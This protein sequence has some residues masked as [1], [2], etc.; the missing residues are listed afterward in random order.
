MYGKVMIVNEFGTP[1]FGDG[2]V[3]IKSS[4]TSL[5]VTVGTAGLSGAL[6]VRDFTAGVFHMGT[7]WTS[8]S[9][10]FKVSSTSTGTF[11]ALYDHGGTLV[12]IPTPAVSCSY[13]VPAEALMGQYVQFWSQTGG[14]TVAQ[15]A[16]RGGTVDLKA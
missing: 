7:A 1:L 14:T 5:A 10:G 16:I 12:Q 13:A 2:E 3:S 8:A 6:D 11:K 15:E 9:I 4:G